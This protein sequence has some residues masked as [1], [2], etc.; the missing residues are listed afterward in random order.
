[1]SA[2]PRL[3]RGVTITRRQVGEDEVYYLVREPRG[4]SFL[5][6]G[7]IEATVLRLLDGSRT[8][9]EVSRALD[10]SHE[11]NVEA[12]VIEE[13]IGS[14]TRKGLVEKR[15]FDPAAFR[16]EWLQQA[17]SRRRSLGQLLGTL[18]TFKLHLINPLG[19]FSRIVGPLSFIWSPA[20]VVASLALM[21]VAGVMGF[22]YSAE[23]LASSRVFWAGMTSSAA[24]FA[25]NALLFYV[26]FF[27]VIAL[28]ELSHGL[29]CAH[30]GGKITDMGFIL[31]YLQVP[32][33][34][35]DITDA[36]SFEK[37]SQRLWTTVAGCYSGLVLASF[38]MI[39]WWATEPGDL[40]N[41]AAIVLMLVG[42]PPVVMFNWNPLLKLDGYYILMD[43]LEAP[44][45]MDNSRKHLGYLFKSR[46]L[47]VPVE[48][49]SVP[50]RLRT[51]YVVYG[52]ASIAFIAPFTIYMPVIV[53]YIFSRLVG[54]ALALPIAAVMAYRMVMVYARKLFE[55]LKYTWLSHR[56]A[57]AGG[58]TGRLRPGMMGAGA[59]A[60]LALLAFGPRFAVRA[61][62]TGTLE[63]LERIEVRAAWPGFVAES[64]GSGAMPAEGALVRAGDP[65]V[66]LENLEVDAG[67]R[68]VDLELAALRADLSRLEARREPA[69]AMMRRSEE[70][71]LQ[72]DALVLA[73]RVEELTLR[74]PI[75]GVVLTPRLQDKLG[76]YLGS[77]ETWCVIGRIDRLRVRVPLSEKDLGLID[78]TSEAG[79]KG[80]HLPGEIFRGRVTRMP[81]GRRPAR[82]GLQGHQPQPVTAAMTAT[83]GEGVSPVSGSLQVEV[84]VDNASGLL[85]PGMTAQ[86]RIYGERMSLA[87][88]AL[89]WAHRLFKGK[90]WW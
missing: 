49:V 81:A 29:T 51:A 89:R 56:P 16:Q 76:A 11:T 38:G 27:V 5:R 54:E 85:R 28:H 26:I 13:F 18:A 69:Q 24:A 15:G 47:R 83:P 14:M 63:P 65:L 55:T 73:R 44:N 53:Y 10:L 61:E 45:L 21:A 32:G 64:G 86:V 62:G 20:F 90:V 12:Q 68:S 78:E 46:V 19:L 25:S 74:A 72:G 37:R 23:V 50:P 42:G 87:A 31:F 52:I 84:E 17:R 67:R 1:M 36:Y 48:P 34:Y 7:E 6:M 58:E 4:G 60:G 9:E 33:V 35:C 79:V 75:A 22:V 2:T 80:P 8:I 40:L 77:G 41:K 59:A 39:L 43:L 57:Q 71:A 3:A 82:P 70:R 66:R 30:F 88:H